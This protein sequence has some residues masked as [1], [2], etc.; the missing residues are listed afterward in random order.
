MPRSL[1][2]ETRVY[3]LETSK[4]KKI[5]SRMIIYSFTE[6]IIQHLVGGTF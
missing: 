4:T 1:G 5:V 3:W 2:T 6:A